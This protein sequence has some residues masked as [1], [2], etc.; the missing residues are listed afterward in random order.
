MAQVGLHLIRRGDE[1]VRTGW[2]VDAVLDA[3]LNASEQIER[4]K[5]NLFP[6]VLVRASPTVHDRHPFGSDRLK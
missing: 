2:A 1:Q 3:S 4:W 6:Q 5:F